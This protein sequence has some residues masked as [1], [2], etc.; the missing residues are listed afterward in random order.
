MSEPDD[1]EI[2]RELSR[3][4]GSERFD[5]WLDTLNVLFPSST[6][7]NEKDVAQRLF[8]LQC[9]HFNAHADALN[10]ARVAV[11][12]L[13]SFPEEFV[14]NRKCLDTD[15]YFEELAEFFEF[16]SARTDSDSM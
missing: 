5:E 9:Q 8:R 7:P 15:G 10:I 11:D 13:D 16:L 2:I 3:L 12:D 6:E 1:L 14:G 4:Q